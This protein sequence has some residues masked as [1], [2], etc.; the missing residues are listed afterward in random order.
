[1]QPLPDGWPAHR[2]DPG[3]LVEQ[4]IWTVRVLIGTDDRGIAG[5][6]NFIKNTDI[7]IKQFFETDKVVFCHLVD[8][9]LYFSDNL[10]R[11]RECIFLFTSRYVR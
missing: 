1:M 7:K 2:Y 10:A 4:F 3:L 11:G 8:A 5:L 6:K 9:S